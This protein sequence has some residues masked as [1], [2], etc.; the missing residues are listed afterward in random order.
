MKHNNFNEIYII[1]DQQYGSTLEIQFNDEW[2]TSWKLLDDDPSGSK[3][4]AS[5]HNKTND[6]TITL[7][8]Y[9]ELVVL[10]SV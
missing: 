3:H 5:I 6:N 8:I 9:Y 10:T 1:N 7:V 2:Y 4:T